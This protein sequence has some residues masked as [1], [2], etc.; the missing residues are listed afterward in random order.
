MRPY[1]TPNEAFPELKKSELDA[2]INYR[3]V[4][5]YFLKSGG[6]EYAKTVGATKNVESYGFAVAKRNIELVSLIDKAL[7]LLKK[8]GEYGSYL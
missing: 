2:V 1:I 4:N 5:E 6:S 8:N 7:V 3:P